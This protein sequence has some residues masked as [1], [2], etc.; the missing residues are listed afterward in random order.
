MF[1]FRATHPEDNVNLTISQS[2]NTS[3]RWVYQKE[4]KTN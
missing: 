4:T 1:Q 2:I 3:N